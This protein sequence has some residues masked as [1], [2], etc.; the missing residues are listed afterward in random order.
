MRKMIIASVED[1]SDRYGRYSPPDRFIRIRLQ[2][3][4]K[5][6]DGKE[7]GENKYMYT[8][9]AIPSPRGRLYSLPLNGNRSEN[10]IRI[11]N[12]IPLHGQQ[13]SSR[14]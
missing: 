9:F 10:V 5:G 1:R 7:P 4:E 6:L 11:F 3:M 13:S 8:M 2:K 14:L 12:S